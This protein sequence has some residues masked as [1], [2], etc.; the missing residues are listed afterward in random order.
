LAESESRRQHGSITNFVAVG[1]QSA[2]LRDYSSILGNIPSDKWTLSGV[3]ALWAAMVSVVLGCVAIYGHSV[4]WRED[5]NMVPALVGQEQNLPYWLW[6]QQVEHRLPFPKAVYL[7][8]LKIGGGDFRIG[9]IANTL[10]LAGLS[11][12]MILTARRI[13]GGQTRLADTFFPLALLHLGHWDNMVWGWAIAFV[14]PTVLVCVW[15]LIIACCPWPLPP[16]IAVTAGLTTVLLPFSSAIGLIF[17]PFVALWL[18][19]GTLLYQRSTSRRW[20]VPFQSACVIISIVFG[21]RYLVHFSPPPDRLYHFHRALSEWMPV[22]VSTMVTG[23]RFV[24]MS[25][26]PVGAGTGRILIS[27]GRGLPGPLLGVVFCGF[28]ALLSVSGMIPL[29]RGLGLYR[30]RTPEGSRFFGC[31][32]FTAAMAALVLAMAWGRSG[33]IPILGMP[34]RYALLS[35]PGLCA[36]YFAW[37]LYGPET[38]RNRFVNGF[39]IAI[40]LTLPFNVRDG[41]AERDFYVTGMRA[42]EQDLAEG[43]S[44]QE[45][46]D[47]HYQFLLAWDRDGLVQRMGM[48]HEAKI[49]PFGGGAPR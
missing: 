31:V 18:A 30:I 19:A 43:L 28:G 47:R 45:L 39:A 36:A 5:W 37:I 49:A 32:I 8:L 42:F 23:V 7:V 41:L 38:T 24:G 22:L 27:T 3:L 14:I 40:L 21:C 10:M 34:S 35:V 9:M 29:R 11:L 15:L 33:W 13:R 12:A 25:L 44:W 1:E 48:L 16:K 46:A 17:T 26:G 6:A 4:P 20:V 2:M